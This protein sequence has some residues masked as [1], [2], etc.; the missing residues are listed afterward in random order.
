MH[1]DV[2]SHQTRKNLASLSSY[3]K[4]VALTA[5][6]SAFGMNTY[7][8]QVGSHDCASSACAVGH[9]AQMLGWELSPMGVKPAKGFTVAPSSCFLSAEGKMMWS[10]FSRIMIGLSTGGE[11]KGDWNWMF[12]GEWE[13]VDN[14]ILGAAARID[15]YLANGVPEDFTVQWSGGDF[16]DE[17]LY[18]YLDKR[19]ALEEQRDAV[20]LVEPIQIDPRVAK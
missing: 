16:T 9:Y 4:K 20:L 13:D 10:D 17:M 3:L 7:Y 6:P 8:A 1:N 15:Y 2:V 5:P 19:T 12:S 18:R 11:T 14:T